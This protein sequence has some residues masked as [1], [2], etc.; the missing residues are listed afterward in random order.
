MANILKDP[1]VK[2]F[3][4]NILVFQDGVDKDGNQLRRSYFPREDFRAISSLT[5]KLR[6]NAILFV[7]E[8][9]EVK[10]ISPK[11]QKQGMQIV[12]EGFKEEEVEVTDIE[13]KA[14]RRLYNSREELMAMPI[15][16]IDEF[17]KL[18]KDKQ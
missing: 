8:G 10:Q 18:I 7:K 11:E 17:E 15:E 5:G 13:R 6:E 12:G 1:S 16:V 3:T 4:F 9:K 14:L 2:A